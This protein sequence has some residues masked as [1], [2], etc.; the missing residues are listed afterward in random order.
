MRALLLT[1]GSEGTKKTAT[2]VLKV[3]LLPALI[4]IRF[5]T[6]AWHM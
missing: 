2:P 6:L 3:T 4:S 1:A 5:K